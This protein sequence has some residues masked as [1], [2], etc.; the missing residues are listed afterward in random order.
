MTLAIWLKFKGQ[1]VKK[2]RSQSV[3]WN[4]KLRFRAIA[5]ALYEKVQSS[6]YDVMHCHDMIA[7][8][9]GVRYKK[10][11]PST[12][13]IWDAH[14]LYEDVSYANPIEKEYISDVIAESAGYVDRFVTISESFRDI[15]SERHPKL[16][17]AAIVMNA[18]RYTQEPLIPSPLRE[19]TG[20]HTDQKILLFQGG[21]GM[22]RGIPQLL[23]AAE[24]IPSDWSIVFMGWGTYEKAID[25]C[26]QQLNLSRAPDRPVI[27]RIPPAPQ[28]ELRSWTA[29][30]TLGI[31]PYENSNLNH[32]Y[33][34]PNKLWEYPNAE[35]PILATDL[36][37]VRQIIERWGT[38]TL[39][40]REF[41]HTDIV[42]KLAQI[43]DAQLSGWRENCRKFSKDMAW[44]TFE[45]EL[46]SV[47]EQ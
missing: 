31:I 35:I 39:L 21:L 15:Y 30:A 37:E 46:L 14:E 28:E 41:D 34:T 36:I 12:T 47:Y 3:Y 9:T 33:C 44:Q 20:I 4:R 11:H 10:H 5:N 45:P 42:A 6:D 23:Q 24:N 13:L 32:L 26:A 27:R 22:Y 18:T 38:G 16:P 7:L 1:I 19:A 40:P 8:I 29:G 17:P 2:F 25:E 43:T